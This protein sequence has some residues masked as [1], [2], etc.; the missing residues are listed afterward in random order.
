[1]Q[2]FIAQPTDACP[3][4]PLLIRLEDSEQTKLGSLTQL[5]QELYELTAAE[6]RSLQRYPLLV[7][8]DGM[9]EQSEFRIES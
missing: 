7:L 1:M 5:L 4:I 2:Q 8:L 9:D 3:W 6:C